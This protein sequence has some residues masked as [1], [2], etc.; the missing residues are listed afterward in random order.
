MATTLKAD[1]RNT[2]KQSELRSLRQQG[3]IPGVI[4]GEK[5]QASIAINEKDLNT[6]LREN[7]NGILTL[8]IPEYGKHSVM[9]T[10][11]Q[12]EPLKGRVIHV[13][14][15]QINMNDEVKATVRVE[16]TG[17]PQGVKEGGILQVVRYDVE[18]K[19]MPSKLPESLELDVSGLQVGESLH[20]DALKLPEGVDL[21]TAPEEILASVLAP[22]VETEPEEQPEPS[23]AAA[24]G[25]AEANE[26]DVEKS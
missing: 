4:Y 12:K 20:V 8:D 23:E 16:L 21:L 2:S 26:G 3:L 9:M 15:H 6:L 18:V 1:L 24:E 10:E 22:K 14:F 11:T 19:C 7:P 25:I 5:V 13:D 17:E